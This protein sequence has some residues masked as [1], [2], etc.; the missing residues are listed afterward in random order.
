MGADVEK[1]ILAQIKKKRNIRAADI[2][3]MTGF[4]RA[5]VNKFF[6]K[7]KAEG[8][9]ALLGKANRA[10]Y[11]KATKG[12]LNRAQEKILRARRILRNRELSED[13]V[14]KQLKQD[15]GIFQGLRKNVRAVVDYA[16]LEMLN[17]AIEHSRSETINVAIGKDDKSIHFN[18]ADK[19]I[20]IFFNIMCKKKLANKME[21]IQDLLKGK[22]TTM[23][24]AH[25]GEGIFFTSK[26]AS[27]LFIQSEKKRLIFN[28]LLPDIFIQDGKNFHGTKV[29]FSI[30]LNSKIS[31]EQVFREYT[32]DSF[33]FNKTNVLVRL[34][35]LDTQYISRSQARRVLSGLQ[36]FKSIVL[37]FKGVDS[38]GQGF[39]DEVFRVWQQC[40]PKI[41]I[42]FRNANENVEFMIKRVL[43]PG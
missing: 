10:F 24:Q 17:N 41:S 14:L 11:V 1:L 42:F 12:E 13:I 26:L 34:Y 27:M 2:V 37:D 39:A 23:P 20:G 33:T 7:L 43:S 9:I 36:Q 30:K 6:Q 25:S 32:E 16:F 3:Q 22:Q 18:I 8:K 40:N 4:S 15:T 29:N 5:Y 38:I 19:G 21:A 35:K 28:N 31:I